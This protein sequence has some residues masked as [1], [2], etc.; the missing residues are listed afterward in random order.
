MHEGG[1]YGMKDAAGIQMVS[2]GMGGLAVCLEVLLYG[3]EEMAVVLGRKEV[4]VDGFSYDHK[5]LYHMLLP[6]FIGPFRVY[7]PL[8]FGHGTGQN[9]LSFLVLLKNYIYFLRKL[10]YKNI[11]LVDF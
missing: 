3:M 2:I 4:K 1:K 9:K 6:L 7:W 8:N 11:F 10:I 5:H